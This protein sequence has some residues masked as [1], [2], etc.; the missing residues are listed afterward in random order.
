MLYLFDFEHVL[1]RKPPTLFGNTLGKEL[2]AD[3]AFFE[4]VFGI[5]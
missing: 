4:V 2:F 1:T 3:D 5:E